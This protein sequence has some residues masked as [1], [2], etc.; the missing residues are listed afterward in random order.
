MAPGDESIRDV[1]EITDL[2]STG[3]TRG[4]RSARGAAA[5]APARSPGAGR[6]PAAADHLGGARAAAGMGDAVPGPGRGVAGSELGDATAAHMELLYQR[7][8]LM[9]FTVDCDGRI[10]GVNG[11]A[12]EQLGYERDELLG[13][14]VDRRVPPRR[15][16]SGPR[17][18]A[19]GLNEPDTTHA[20][21]LRKVPSRRRRALGGGVGPRRAGPAGRARN[22]SSPARTSP[23]GA[24]PSRPCATARRD[25]CRRRNRRRS[26]D[27]PAASRT[28][29]ATC[30]PW[31]SDTA[32]PRASCCR[33][34]HPCSRRLQ[35]DPRGCAAGHQ[36]V[37]AAAHVQP[38]PGRAARAAAARRHRGADD[39]AVPAAARRRASRSRSCG[40]PACRAC[41][42]IRARSSRC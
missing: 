22:C 2:S 36:P 24:A 33:A 19:L 9:Y 3:R 38:A 39:A 32:T 37:A 4:V 35:G 40:C 25:C 11:T 30:S 31:C 17:T 18:S 13:R 27:S 23:R 8:P 20:W 1:F 14:P 7:S 15:P 10:V 16:G 21:A 6:S 42:P 26:G 41:S 29:S 34:T 12:L 5:R 28:T